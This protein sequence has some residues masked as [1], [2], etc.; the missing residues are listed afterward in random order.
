[1][2]RFDLPDHSRRLDTLLRDLGYAGPD[3]DDEIDV[4]RA[5]R[6]VNRRVWKPFEEARLKA[7][8]KGDIMGKTSR[9]TAD[10]AVQLADGLG[11]NVLR[12]LYE[13]PPRHPERPKN[14]LDELDAI[15]LPD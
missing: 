9:L 15:G 1:M 12:L 11:F 14:L 10:E 13:E 5:A 6:V 2:P 4:A 3:G 8:L 7:I